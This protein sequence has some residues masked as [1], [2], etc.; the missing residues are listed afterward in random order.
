MLKTTIV[1]LVLAIIAAAIG[2]GGDR[3]WVVGLSRVAFFL[4]LIFTLV[5]V[6][7]GKPSRSV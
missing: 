3:G 5:G 7:L 6:F 1:L 2:F 4:L